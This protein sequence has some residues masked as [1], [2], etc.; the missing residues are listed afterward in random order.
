M[1]F[2]RTLRRSILAN[3]LILSA[4]SSLRAQTP[5]KSAAFTPGSWSLVLLPDTQ[6][7][8]DSYPDLFT[9]QTRWIAKNKDKY[10]IRYVLG[11]GDITDKNTDREWRNAKKAIDQLDGHVPYALASG[12]HDYSPHGDS[13]SGRSGINE[14]FPPSKFEKWPT[15]GGVMKKGNITNS[16]HLFSA[17]KTDWIV[18]V[19]E[20]AP[21]DAAVKWANEVLAK[22]PKRKA[23]LVTHAYLFDDN[24]RYD[25][26]KKGKKQKWNPHS[27][28]RKNCNDGEE[29]WQKLVRKNNFA[30]V[31][32]GHVS[33]HCYGF[34]VSK[35]DRGNRVYQMLADY[36]SRPRGGEAYL[37]LLEF[38]PDGKTV[39]V[40][41]YSPLCDKYLSDAG[42]QFSFELDR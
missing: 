4:A 3:L 29:L 37:R 20:W 19:L 38:L 33:I 9:L 24:A 25:F 41:S 30:L 6:Y 8:S 7:Y 15:F 28:T 10:D 40:K 32:C 14:F 23:I 1:T 21:S 16:Y 34:L 26:A 42:N 35:N 17:G 12:N 22:Y 36:Q 31:V 11:L 2:H 39:H 18:I 27:Y 5:L 13:A